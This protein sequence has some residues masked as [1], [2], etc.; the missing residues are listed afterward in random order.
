MALTIFEFD[1]LFGTL[2]IIN[3]D[4]LYEEGAIPC[5]YTR[6]DSGFI[7][8]VT[9]AYTQHLLKYILLIN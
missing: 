1:E 9:P 5:Q 4:T 2:F 7:K 6:S 3:E 8:N